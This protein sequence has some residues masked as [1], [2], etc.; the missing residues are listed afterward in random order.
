MKNTAGGFTAVRTPIDRTPKKYRNL[1]KTIIVA[2]MNKAVH[3]AVFQLCERLFAYRWDIM[4]LI[5]V[6]LFNQSV[7]ASADILKTVR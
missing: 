6:I 7:F 4:T 1:K 2:G 3:R 5:G